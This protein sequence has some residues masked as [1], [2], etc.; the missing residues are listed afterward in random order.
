MCVYLKVLMARDTVRV[1]YVHL[2]S[3][4]GLTLKGSK[5]GLENLAWPV[6]SL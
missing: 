1:P 2:Q 3:G 5:I 4:C 6:R